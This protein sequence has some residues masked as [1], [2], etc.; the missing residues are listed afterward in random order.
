MPLPILTNAFD[1]NAFL[2]MALIVPTSMGIVVVVLATCSFHAGL[3]FGV[4][5]GADAGQQTRDGM[6]TVLRHDFIALSA[7]LVS[8][9]IT[10]RAYFNI[11]ADM[12][13]S[14]EHAAAIFYRELAQ[15]LSAASGLLFSATLV[16]AFAPGFVALTT[17]P[18]SNA[19]DG[20]GFP[21]ILS[22]FIFKPGAISHRL[23]GLWQ[24]VLAF[25]AP[26]MSAPLLD[27]L[28]GFFG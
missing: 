18:D 8:S 9:V 21:K 5:A 23:S 3:F 19:G 28:S 10:A 6:S 17:I 14:D 7:V 13:S 2:S 27:L 12:F 16:A 25:I 24:A 1:F 11:P 20:R 15:S 26:A 22:G 4:R